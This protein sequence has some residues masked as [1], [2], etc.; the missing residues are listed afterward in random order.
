M[1]RHTSK[2]LFA[3]LL[4]SA[5]A[6]ASD[7]VIEDAFS[8]HQG[9]TQLIVRTISDARRSIRVAAYSFSSRAIG[10]ALVA[11]RRKGVDVR[12][13]L[14][15]RQTSARSLVSFLIWNGVPTRKNSRYAIMHDK[16]MIID[17]N[18]LELGSFNYTKAAEDRNAENV[19]VIRNT[20]RI[21]QDYTTQWERLWREAEAAE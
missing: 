18:I 12:V 16:F 17:G 8:P 19:L 15:K 11:A 6:R 9:A 5:P 14:D 3:A 10:E 7:I 13:V 4:L 20:P 21:I 1:L 2:L